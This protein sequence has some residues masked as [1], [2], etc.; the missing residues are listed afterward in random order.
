LRVRNYQVTK[1][2]RLVEL[3]GA[4]IVVKF[5][6]LAQRICLAP[7]ALFIVS[8][9]QRPRDLDRIMASALKARFIGAKRRAI[10]E[11]VGETRFQ[12]W[13]TIQSRTGGI[14]PG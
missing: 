14:A 2:S 13:A 5:E 9:G 6:S 11:P 1:A 12:R 10:N 4:Q 7:T 3:D 8:L